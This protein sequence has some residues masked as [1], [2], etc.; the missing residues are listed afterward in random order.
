MEKRARSITLLQHQQ[1]TAIGSQTNK[2]KMEGEVEKRIKESESTFICVFL[3][4][5]V[6]IILFIL[7]CFVLAPSHYFTHQMH[8]T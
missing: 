6:M 4:H 2:Q 3:L 8:C 1:Y 7:F 5:Q